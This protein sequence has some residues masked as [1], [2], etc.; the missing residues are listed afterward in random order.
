MKLI[1]VGTVSL[2][3]I[4][5]VG[6]RL[7]GDLDE[8]PPYLFFGEIDVDHSTGVVCLQ[9]SQ[10]ETKYARPIA[11][12]INAS[13]LKGTKVHPFLGD[14]QKPAIEPVR[15]TKSSSVESNFNPSVKPTRR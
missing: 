2:N 9:K 7:V 8:I 6:V 10:L 13:H 1:V 14:S 15:I 11:E 5:V 4:V 12:L 3:P